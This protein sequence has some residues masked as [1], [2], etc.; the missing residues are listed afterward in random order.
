[1]DK[2]IVDVRAFRDELNA[3]ELTDDEFADMMYGCNAS[4]SATQRKTSHLNELPW[5]IWQCRDDRARCLE[6]VQQ[7]DLAVLA[8]PRRE[9]GM[10]RVALKFAS[11]QLTDSVRED[12]LAY[13]NGVP[14]TSALDKMFYR[15]VT[16][17]SMNETLHETPHRDTTRTLKIASGSKSIW[18]S[19]QN[20]RLQSLGIA[21]ACVRDK[22]ATTFRHAWEKATGVLSTARAS[23]GLLVKPSRTAYRIAMKKI[24]CTY[25][26]N[27]PNVEAVEDALKAADKRTTGAKAPTWANEKLVLKN[28]TTATLKLKDIVIVSQ[29]VQERV[30]PTD[31]QDLALVP[32]FS[33]NCFKLWMITRP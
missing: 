5:L 14:M 7:F 1:V 12:M 16:A 27:K 15:Y 30:G 2:F 31:A 6:F 26:Y 19:V 8:S 25:P 29:P 28:F 17:V 9:I 3:A 23:A 13:G 33:L 24:Y 32:L 18:W 11:T 4:I 21:Q 20:R 10:H 22:G